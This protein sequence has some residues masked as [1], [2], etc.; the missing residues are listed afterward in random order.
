MRNRTLGDGRA[1]EGWNVMDNPAGSEFA[2]DTTGQEEVAIWGAE[3]NASDA[4]WMHGELNGRT[5]D[6][7]LGYMASL[8]TWA[9]HGAAY[10]MGDFSNN[11]K[12][13][14]TGGWEREGG[15]YRSGLNSI[16]VVE[17]YRRHPDDFYL[18][19]VGVAGIMAPLPNIDADGAPSMAFHTHPFVME[20]DPNS[21][22]H[23]LGFFGSSLNAGAYLHAHPTL[24]ALCFMCV[25]TSPPPGSLPAAAAAAPLTFEPRDMYRRR[26]FVSS[27]GLWLVAEAG[28][29]VSIEVAADASTVTVLF[30]PSA[31]AAAAAGTPGT[32]APYS[33]LRLRV[34]QAAPEDRGFAFALTAPAGAQIVRGAYQFAPSADDSATTAAVIAVSGAGGV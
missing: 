21:G 20:H 5:V 28:T 33:A 32:A 9:F 11:A 25:I 26:A 1:W 17:R 23:G 2:W 15:H 13:M 30:A 18:L 10:G 22:D 6:S 14:V 34:E 31:A 29:F 27:L 24:G 12:W 7:I 16:P 19:Q 3:F 8:P 4:G